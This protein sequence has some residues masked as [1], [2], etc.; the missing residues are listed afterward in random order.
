MTTTD[1]IAPQQPQ[2]LTVAEVAT[3]LNLS[4]C[5][6]YQLISEGEIP[7]GQFGKS[8]RVPRQWINRR[9]AEITGD[10][11]NDE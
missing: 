2:F 1:Q 8:I 3:I 4:R 9:I 6:V 5:H 10:T 11:D 7:S